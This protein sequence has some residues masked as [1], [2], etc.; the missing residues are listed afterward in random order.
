MAARRAAVVCENAA[1]TSWF[2]DDLAAIA[3]LRLHRH[4]PEGRWAAIAATVAGDDSPLVVALIKGGG[5]RGGRNVDRS[6]S[7]HDWDAFGRI[8]D[9]LASHRWRRPAAPQNGIAVANASDPQAH[10]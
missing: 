2:V 3:G 10:K 6:V 1:D 7:Q 8:D 4:G 5:R 9:D